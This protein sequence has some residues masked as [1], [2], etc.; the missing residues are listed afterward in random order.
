MY[1]DGI[2]TLRY[3]I[4]ALMEKMFKFLTLLWFV[5]LSHSYAEVSYDKIGNGECLDSNN[6]GFFCCKSAV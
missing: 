2:Y 4:D 6:V 1:L 5:N 3:C